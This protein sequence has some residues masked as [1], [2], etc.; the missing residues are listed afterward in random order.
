MLYK[1][2][3]LFLNQLSESVKRFF[4]LAYL[5]LNSPFAFSENLVPH[6]E[7]ITVGFD[8]R[9]KPVEDVSFY[10]PLLNYLKESTGYDFKFKVPR[11][12][13][14]NINMLGKGEIDISIMGSV[15]CLVSKIKYGAYPIVV[16]LNNQKEPY[17]NSAI[18]KNVNNKNI[19]N[20]KEL[21]GKR[22]AF[23]N[24]FSTQGYIIPRKMLEDNGISYH[25]I[26]AEFSISH[27]D[28]AKKVI[29]NTVDAGAIQDKLAFKLEQQGLVKVISLSD[30]YPSSTICVSPRLDKNIVLSIKNALI[31]LNP[32]NREEF[33]RKNWDM[34]EMSG[35]FVDA[36]L[37]DFSKVEKLIQKYELYR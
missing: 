9:W 29:N 2:T 35:G 33:L 8:L 6:Y 15:S 13:E 1:Q 27:D 32:L 31:N 17:Y 5:L 3:R 30:D 12:Y 16:G 7:K 26:Y 21:K 25:D 4:I 19:N 18:I 34:T 20:I 24:R 37:V 14:E 23:G 10:L 28:V 11:S 22:F 36:S